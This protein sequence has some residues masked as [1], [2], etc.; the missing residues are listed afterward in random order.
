M[1]VL[2]LQQLGPVL[3]GRYW[4][5][6]TGN[7]GYEGGMMFGN[8]WL[9]ASQRLAGGASGG[10]PWAV[11]AGGGVVAGDGQGDNFAQFGHLTWPN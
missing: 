11:Y 4:V 1:D 10:G 6:A 3:P 9:L 8:L 5:D 7:V 2:G